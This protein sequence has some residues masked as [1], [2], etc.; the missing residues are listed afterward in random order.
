MA[1]TA[2]IAEE[3]HTH[4]GIY[5]KLS[6][7]R[8]TDLSKSDEVSEGALLRASSNEAG[9]EYPFGV[10]RV[11]NYDYFLIGSNSCNWLI[12]YS[13]IFLRVWVSHSNG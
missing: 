11:F 13:G 7:A 9:K 10:G 12:L 6:K 4:Y 3:H 1:S 8:T 2:K 5:E